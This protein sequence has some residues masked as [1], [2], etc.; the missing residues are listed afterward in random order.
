MD[1]REQDGV[2]WLQAEL[3][4]ATAAFSTRI[5]GVSQRPYDSLNVAVLT[6]DERDAVRENRRRLAHTL[7][8]D[9][10]GVVMGR[11]V[12]GAA[13][14]EH[15]MRPEHR[16]YADAVRSPEEVDA[17]A[18]TNPE[19]TPL[20]MELAEVIPHVVLRELAED[21]RVFDAA[22]AQQAVRNTQEAWLARRA[23]WTL[24]AWHARA[25]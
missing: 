4:G 9:P 11:Q 21:G 14:R 22:V 6:G 16:V 13:L 15:S 8:R 7:H 19:L 25:R 20:V 17:H 3:P 5:G 23:E 10:A 18:T 1:W 24:A 2:H 12:H